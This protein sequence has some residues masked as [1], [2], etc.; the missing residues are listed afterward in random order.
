M[1]SWLAGLAGFAVGMALMRYAPWWR[2]PLPVPLPPVAKPSP[3][4]ERGFAM[5][6]AILKGLP[7]PPLLNF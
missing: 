5:V 7:D 1:W 2:K 4:P 3:K 6:E